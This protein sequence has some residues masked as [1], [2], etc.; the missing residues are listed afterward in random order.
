MKNE[1]S[2]ERSVSLFL[3]SFVLGFITCTAE[4]TFSSRP[5][6]RSGRPPNA[7]AIKDYKARAALK[8]Y[9]ERNAEIDS[10]VEDNSTRDYKNA[11]LLYYQALLLKPD[12]DQAVINKFYDVYVGARPDTQIRAFLGEWLPSMKVAEI[13]S[14]ILQC[15]WEIYHEEFWPPEKRSRIFLTRSFRR[16]SY[17]IA[18]DA[19]TLAADG[20]YHAALQRCMTVRRIA[21]HLSH[22][23]LLV[24]S[25]GSCDT[26]AFRTMH[27][28]LA[29]MPL[30]VDVLTQFQDQLEEFQE[31][32]TFLERKLQEHLKT[33][34]E[35][36][37][38]SSTAR[39][40]GM[41]IKRASD[42][43]ARKNI[44]VLSDDQMRN[45]AVET[46]QESYNS[47]LAILRNDKS[48]EQ[49]KT[50]ILEITNSPMNYVVNSL[51]NMDVFE[52]LSDIHNALGD[53]AVRL[54]TGFYFR[55][56]EEQNLDEVQ[57]IIDKSAEPDTIEL[58]TR[59]SIAMGE[60]VDFGFLTSQ[61]LTV[62]QKQARMK[63]AIV[64]LNEAYAIETEKSPFEFLWY[65]VNSVFE[66]EVART[67]RMRIINIAVELYITLA[68]TG[69]LP[70][71]LPD[72]L[73]KDPY[74]N[75]KFFYKITE[76]CFDLG[77]QS[78]VFETGRQRFTFS[79]WNKKN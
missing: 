26:I 56:T 78:D 16:L 5:A 51:K 33:K 66:L 61:E 58:L 27:A 22:D 69:Q 41:L 38:S 64:K 74:T 20:K 72:Y 59:F 23:S 75:E 1:R 30:D 55:S 76:D 43:Q 11:A 79:T 29:E 54:I 65:S 71:E 36:V 24:L 39:L 57:R 32:A 28:I 12:H 37:H 35:I 3:F 52:S 15:N 14:R 63:K 7:S 60:E 8:A 62:E 67:A 19:K 45:K 10:W 13:A 68:K 53:G 18:V 77:W 17:I 49:K 34:I 31:P 4:P 25:S 48:A 9:E 2:R 40:R 47:T 70:R 21:R 50:E 46:I 73:P 42:E 44:R 6:V